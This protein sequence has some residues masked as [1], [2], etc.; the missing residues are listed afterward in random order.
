MESIN[1]L[2]HDLKELV[3][4]ARDARKRAYAPYSKFYVGAA[5][6]S[7]TGLIF[8]GCNIENA[9]YAATLC[10]E[11]VALSTAVAAGEQSLRHLAIVADLPDPLLP[12]GICRQVLNELAP[13]V[14]VIM[15]NLAGQVR[16]S[17]IHELLPLP[18]RFP[19]DESRLHKK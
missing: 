5:I 14:L 17:T 8:S 12:C 6:R 1:E 7:E 19:V 11:R 9:T 2:S 3:F 10:A 15:S 18:F 4:L 16:Q 13:D